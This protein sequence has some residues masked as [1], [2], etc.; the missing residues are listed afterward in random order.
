[1]D[2]DVDVSRIGSFLL[3]EII[4]T[5]AVCDVGAIDLHIDASQ[6]CDGLFDQ[7]LHAYPVTHDFLKTAYALAVSAVSAIWLGQYV[8][9]RDPRV[10]SMTNQVAIAS[11]VFLFCQSVMTWSLL[12]ECSC[13][14][15]R[16]SL[17]VCLGL[18][19]AACSSTDLTVWARRWCAVAT[20]TTVSAADSTRAKLLTVARD[21]FATK[22]FYG[23]TTRDIAA[24]AGISP[25]AV[26]VHHR[27]KESLLFAI[28]LAGHESPV[29]RYVYCQGFRRHADGSIAGNDTQ[30]RA[31]AHYSAHDRQSG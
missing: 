29:E 24:A 22:G 20:R 21:S 31:R 2:Y 25:A 15:G 30:L 9:N 5:L 8:G 19:G 3:G 1:M 10:P 26:Y 7:S 11:L 23:T 18:H 6:V 4:K 12:R 16:F 14:P 13:V 17:S 27:T 28:S